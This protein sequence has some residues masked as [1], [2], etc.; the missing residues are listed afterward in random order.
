MVQIRLASSLL[1]REKKIW[2]CESTKKSLW[3]IYSSNSFFFT[4]R[5]QYSRSSKNALLIC[6]RYP[7]ISA[8]QKG[9]D[10]LAIYMISI[11]QKHI[12]LKVTIWL[13]NWPRKIL[14]NFFIH[15]QEHRVINLD[16]T[17]ILA[18]TKGHVRGFGIFLHHFVFDD[19][20]WKYWHSGGAS[21]QTA[22]QS[23][24]GQIVYTFSDCLKS[25]LF[26]FHTFAG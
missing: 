1:Q 17:F 14:T 3:R 13:T 10:H 8:Y 5:L 15:E 16:N 22:A 12:L 6:I 23:A 2:R 25:R 4:K 21:Y 19:I 18:S 20:Y 9:P 26:D 24:V 7:C 11:I